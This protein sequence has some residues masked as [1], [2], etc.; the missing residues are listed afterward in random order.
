MEEKIK[1]DLAVHREVRSRLLRLTN[2]LSKNDVRANQ[3]GKNTIRVNTGLTHNQITVLRKMKFLTADL[4][5][6]DKVKYF[7]VTDIDPV[8]GKTINY[9]NLAKILVDLCRERQRLS[10]A[11]KSI[12]DMVYPDSSKNY[13]STSS[14]NI[15]PKSTLEVKG[16]T[17]W[18]I[19][20]KF[21]SW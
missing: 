15:D 20:K 21:F 7:Q 6:E 12:K 10:S 2:F 17:F 18:K 1:K 9:S 11:G 13:S 4:I 5:F 19:I 16:P 3:K 8:N 14:S